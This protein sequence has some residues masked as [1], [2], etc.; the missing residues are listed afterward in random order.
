MPFQG[1]AGDYYLT[2]KENVCVVCGKDDS[3]LRKYIVPHDYRK[4]FPG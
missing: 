4:H 2:F 3:Y 1:V